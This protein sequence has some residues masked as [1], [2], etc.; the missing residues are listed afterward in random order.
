MAHL[1]VRN[2]DDEIVKALETRA[3]QNGISA[4]AEHRKILQAALIS[5]RQKSFAEVLQ[6]MPNVGLDSDFASVQD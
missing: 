6:S 2:I 4:E 1:V 3:R 5:P